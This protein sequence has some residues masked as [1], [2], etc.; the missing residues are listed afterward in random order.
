[1]KPPTEDELDEPLFPEDWPMNAPLEPNAEMRLMAHAL[2]QMYL[3]LLQEGFSKTE[4]LA[5]CAE[6]IRASIAA[7]AA[8]QS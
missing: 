1:M 7:A 4:A 3:A 2:R 8:A 5:I 6:C